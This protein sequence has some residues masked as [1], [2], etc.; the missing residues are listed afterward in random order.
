MTDGEINVWILESDANRRDM[1]SSD[2]IFPNDGRKIVPAQWLQVK[3]HE[4]TSPK[5]PYFVIVTNEE[6]DRYIKDK[7][8]YDEH[9]VMIRDNL[10]LYVFEQ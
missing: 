8:Y 10:R 1:T 2:T 7:N 6:Y 4:N 5:N 3:T 9:F